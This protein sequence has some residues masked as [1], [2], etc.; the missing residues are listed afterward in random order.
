LGVVV[1]SS[2]FGLVRGVGAFTTVL[3]TFV[4]V[5]RIQ[6]AEQ[7]RGNG[8][9]LSATSSSRRETMVG[10]TLTRVSAL[11]V[12]LGLVPVYSRDDRGVGNLL[13]YMHTSLV[14]G[15]S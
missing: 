11:R 4:L 1:V 6:L 8:H 9:L 7:Y 5:S 14:S 15:P 10:D 13:R 12:G 2:I 3:P